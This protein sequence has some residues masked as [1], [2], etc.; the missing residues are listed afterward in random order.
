M[1]QDSGRNQALNAMAYSLGRLAPRWVDPQEIADQLLVACMTNGLVAEDGRKQCEKTIASGLTKG[2]LVPR[3]PPIG[4]DSDVEA[5]LR[6]LPSSDP[7]PPGVDPQ[8]GEMSP[9]PAEAPENIDDILARAHARAVENAVRDLR[10]KEEAGRAFAA[11]LAARNFRIPPSRFTLTEELLEPDQP[12][13]YAVEELLPTG[14]NALLAAQFK[15]GKTTLVTNLLKA[16]ADGEPFLGRFGVNPGP[17]RIAIFNYELSPDQ[18]RRWLREAGI[19]N[20]DRIAVL[21]LRGYRLPITAPSV[22]DFIVGWL[23]ER[24]CSVWI[25]DPFARAATGTDENS[26]TEV[27]VWL[28][29]FDVIKERA[30][31]SEGVLPT[32]TGRAEQEHGQERARGATRLD[33]WADVR[34]LLTKDE[35]DNRFFRATGRDVSVPEE[36]LTFDAD[37]R[38]LRIGGGDRRWVKGRDAEARV[39]AWVRDHPGEKTRDI[40]SRAGGNKP[41]NEA[42]LKSLTSGHSPAIR[43]E[44]DGQSHRHYATREVL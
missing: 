33:D 6:T 14:G 1:G 16:Y 3:D 24:E 34:W 38:S 36:L 43:I 30:G 32:H 28:D 37:S 31:V 44:K 5:W 25:A 11:E 4:D 9:D 29:T 21:H 23:K 2:M 17:G 7:A 26:N 10:V 27:G 19:V 13:T 22:E 18:Y 15:A 40:Q 39:F 42:A 20:T 35:N 12:T 41:E 8:A